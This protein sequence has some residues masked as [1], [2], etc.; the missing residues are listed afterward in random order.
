[1]QLDSWVGTAAPPPPHPGVPL[2]EFGCCNFK[3]KRRHGQLEMDV[4]G[5]LYKA[6]ESSTKCK[7]STISRIN[8]TIGSQVWGLCLNHWPLALRN[9][10]RGD[11][12]TPRVLG[13]GKAPSSTHY[14]PERIWAC[15]SLV[16]A[17][18]YCCLTNQWIASS[19]KGKYCKLKPLFLI[20]ATEV[21]S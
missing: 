18:G 6:Q 4:W 5:N 3:E 10:I 7:S 12:S 2:W 17:F 20:C 14:E 21:W 13:N 15:E 1:M 9:Y 19:S 11:L 8:L 16:P